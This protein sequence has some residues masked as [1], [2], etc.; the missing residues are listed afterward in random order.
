MALRTATDTGTPQAAH[1]PSGR[2]NTWLLRK[3]TDLAAN[4]DSLAGEKFRMVYFPY[5]K[6]EGTFRIIALGSS[7][8]YGA[9]IGETEKTWPAVLQKK[10]GAQC[11]TNVEVLNAGWGGYNSF[12]LAI[13]LSKVLWRYHP[14]LV[15]FYYGGNE[16]GDAT[17]K[18]YYDHLQAEIKK[19]GSPGTQERLRILRYGTGRPQALALLDQLSDLASYRLLRGLIVPEKPKLSFKSELAYS[20]S[21]SMEMMEKAASK[22]GFPIVMIP[23]IYMAR[24]SDPMDFAKTELIGDMTSSAQ[25]HGWPI[26]DLRSDFERC[27]NEPIGLDSVHFSPLGAERMAEFLAEKVRRLAPPGL[28][29]GE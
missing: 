8:T 16:D 19:A 7:S 14:D 18:E 11:R 23:E 1:H 24:G 26:I 21:S 22:H 28:E 4:H 13:W 29:C 2:V 3:H 15:L 10:L 20:L 12:Q 17:P 6:P 9:G 25:M 27:R 5:Q